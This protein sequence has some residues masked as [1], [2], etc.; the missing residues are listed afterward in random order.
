MR[1]VCN[2]LECILWKIL[3]KREFKKSSRVEILQTGNVS[4]WIYFF[5]LKFQF[6]QN[7]NFNKRHSQQVFNANT[8]YNS[9]NSKCIP[10][11]STKLFVSVK[12]SVKWQ[13]FKRQNK[14][15]KLFNITLENQS[16]EWK[17]QL[18]M[19]IPSSICKYFLNIKYS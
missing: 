1:E 15:K 6:N 14:Q 19:T 8:L 16:R 17:W 5:E 3:G 12:C 7:S 2:S 18:T 9:S 4:L 10:I 13:N 11:Q